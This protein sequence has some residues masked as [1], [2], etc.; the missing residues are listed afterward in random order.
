[1]YKKHINPHRVSVP[2]M[3]WKKNPPHGWMIVTVTDAAGEPV[4]DAHITVSGRDDVALSGTD[5]F[6]GVLNLVPGQTTVT[7]AKAGAGEASAEVAIER[8]KVAR[9]ELKLKQ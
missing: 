3:P 9:L 6:A 2:D 5:G 8:G 1:F 7:A 4:R